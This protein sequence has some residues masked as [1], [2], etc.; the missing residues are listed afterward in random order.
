MTQNEVALQIAGD[1]DKTMTALA[2]LPCEIHLKISKYLDYDDR[3]K[4]SHS[5]HR[6]R[7][8]SP[9]ATF[10][11]W[12]IAQHRKHRV[13]RVFDVL[14]SWDSALVLEFCEM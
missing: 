4:T 2:N 3:V 10:S 12:L 6:C 14:V 8:N 9:S 1:N 11:V 7:A 5:L 13:A